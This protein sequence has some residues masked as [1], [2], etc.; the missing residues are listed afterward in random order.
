MRPHFDRL[1]PR[2]LLSLGTPGAITPGAD[3]N[4]WFTESVGKVGRV[5]PAGVMTE[6][7]IIGAGALNGIAAGPDNAPWAADTSGRI[8]RVSTSGS[9]TAYPPTVIVTAG[10]ETPAQPPSGYAYNPSGSPWTFT[11]AS[12]V[13]ANGSPFTGA[14]PSGTDHPGNGPAPEG[15]QVA[16]LQGPGSSISQVINNLAAGTYQLSF[17]AAQRENYNLP[18]DSF[19]MIEVEIDGNALVTVTPAAPQY[20]SFTTSLVTVTG[21]THTLAFKGLTASDTT[22]LLDGVSLVQVNPQPLADLGFETPALPPKAYGYDPIGSPWTFAG[23]SGITA[24][25]SS[26][27]GMVANGSRAVGNDAPEGL[28]VAFLQGNGSSISQAIDNW[29]AGT[30]QVNFLAEK[31]ANYN[32]PGVDPQ[33]I[34]VDV[35]G[36]PVLTVTPLGTNYDSFSTPTFAVNSGAHTLTFKGL[37]PGD[38]TVFIDAASAV[39]VNSQPVAGSG[40]EAPALPAN[41]YAYAPTASDWTYAGAAGIAAN[42]SAFTASGAAGSGITGNPAP[43]GVQVAFLQDQASS[44]S[45]AIANWAAGTYQIHFLAG[46]RDNYSAPTAGLQAI[47]VDVDG[48]A[49]LTITPGSANYL[50]LTTPAFTVV[51]GAHTIDFKSLTAGDT[52]AFLDAV[53]VVQVP[54]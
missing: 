20:K 27:T 51:A 54:A 26:F 52:T 36:K 38:T 48:N 39:R 28:Q 5:T 46:Q 45:Q 24:N 31:R 42:G 8:D 15:V 44:I 35:D 53:S 43:E 3:G 40:F 34:E 19:Q 37:T 7:P 29:T 10:F 18:A 1:E 9:I 13:A 25:N 41:G 30:Y 11:G 23:A 47:E 22:A 33:T 21:G 6:F 2:S 32:G 12:G 17:L 14:G 50:S 4:L 16:F 49:I